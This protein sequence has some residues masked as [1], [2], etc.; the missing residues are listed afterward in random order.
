[1]AKFKKKRYKFTDEI[2]TT[3]MIISVVS[4]TLGFLLIL[5][6][7]I[8]SIV[9]KGNVGFPTG[10]MV[11]SGGLIGL[12][13]LIFSIFSYRNTDGGVLMK[14]FSLILNLINLFIPVFL[15]VKFR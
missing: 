10:T 3:D 12:L 13:G 5:G 2:V 8:Y 4:G 15:F 11:L 7:F 9:K 6:A 14:R 1:M